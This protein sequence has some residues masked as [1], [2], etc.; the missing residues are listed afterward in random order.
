MKTKEEVMLKLV[1]EGYIMSNENW[2]YLCGLFEE[3]LNQGLIKEPTVEKQMDVFYQTIKMIY[4]MY[5]EKVEKG[6]DTPENI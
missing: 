4:M 6:I 3:A 1:D 2:E 5:G